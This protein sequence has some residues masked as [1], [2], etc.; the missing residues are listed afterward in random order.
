METGMEPSRAHTSAKVSAKWRT[1]ID[2]SPLN[3][4]DFF[5]LFFLSRSMNYSLWKNCNVKESGRKDPGSAAFSKSAPDWMSSWPASHPSTSFP[6]IQSAVFLRNP[7]NKPT[8][9]RTWAQTKRK[10]IWEM[11]ELLVIWDKRVRHMNVRNVNVTQSQEKYP[12]MYWSKHNC[13]TLLCTLI[14]NWVI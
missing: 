1:P 2:T 6:E 8:N 5:S 4:P 13:F 7:A 11:H 10:F 3:M 12:I 14:R 9:Q